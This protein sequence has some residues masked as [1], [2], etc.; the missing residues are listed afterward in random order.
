VRRRDWNPEANPGT[1]QFPPPLAAVTRQLSSVRTFRRGG[2]SCK[3][4]WV[5]VRQA[6]SASRFTVTTAP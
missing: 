5:S 4:A 2:S 6:A 3:E 1:P